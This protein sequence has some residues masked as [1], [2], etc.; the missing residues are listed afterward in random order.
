MAI[1]KFKDILNNAITL[2]TSD[3][4][5]KPTAKTEIQPRASVSSA[6]NTQSSKQWEYLVVSFVDRLQ[7]SLKP[8]CF[9]YFGTIFHFA[10]HSKSYDNGLNA[11]PPLT[12]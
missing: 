2:N 1:I 5:N 3:T 6:V 9:Q 12:G 7:L 10:P 11:N 8:A 4:N